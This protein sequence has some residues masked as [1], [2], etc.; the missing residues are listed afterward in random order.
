M[1][2]R[3]HPDPAELEP[4]EAIGGLGLADLAPADRP[5]V[6]CNMIASVDGRIAI[7]G[8]SGGLGSKLDR[9][10]FQLLRTQV[11]AVMAG[12]GTLRAER[13]GRLIRDEALRERRV[14]AGLAPE[15][16][17]FVVTRTG[18]V[19]WDIPLFGDPDTVA[20]VATAADVPPP[21]VPATVHLLRFAPGEL[22]MATALARLRAEHGVRSVLCEGGPL[23]NGAL[24]AD[25]ALDE[26]FLSFSPVLASGQATTMIEGLL[27]E[28]VWLEL[29]W[30]LEGD[31]ML[32]LRYRVHR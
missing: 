14:T 20:V 16:I 29:R 5:Y 15:P 3:L 13:Y 18:D 27:E 12:T 7:Q 9:Q 4:A 8:R 26:L 24:L 2:R 19:P 23:V 17:A 31:G 6:V 21:D 30:V 10:V 32:F 28:L 11:D 25:G 22:T 1:L